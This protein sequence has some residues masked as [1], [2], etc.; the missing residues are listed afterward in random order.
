LHNPP[1][2]SVFIFHKI[3]QILAF[4][5]IFHAYKYICKYLSPVVRYPHRQR[6]R[7]ILPLTAGEKPERVFPDRKVLAYQPIAEPV[8]HG[9]RKKGGFSDE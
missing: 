2:V 3:S 9:R 5:N 7:S 1:L 6:K 4:V 8:F